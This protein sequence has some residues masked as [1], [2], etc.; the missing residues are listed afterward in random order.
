MLDSE[1]EQ[2]PDL[3]G[4]LKV[5]SSPEWWKVRLPVERAV[6]TSAS[7]T[8]AAGTSVVPGLQAR[9]LRAWNALRGR[10][11]ESAPDAAHPV[12][13]EAEPD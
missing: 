5:A 1:I 10:W 6:S 8:S 2:L 7:A 13:R 9:A 11:V 3:A 12:A 4:Y